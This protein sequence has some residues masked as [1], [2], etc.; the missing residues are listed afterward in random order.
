MREIRADLVRLG[1]LKDVGEFYNLVQPYTF[2]SPSTAA[3]VLLGRA[4]NGRTDWKTKD[5]KTLKTLQET[6]SA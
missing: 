6:G 4:T 5:G 2:S 3:G 1:V